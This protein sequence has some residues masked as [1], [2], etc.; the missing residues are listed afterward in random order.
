M[1]EHLYE[2][3][4]RK[5]AR[6]RETLTAEIEAAS[7]AFDSLSLLEPVTTWLDEFDSQLEELENALE[8]DD[9][10]DDAPFSEEEVEALKSWAEMFEEHVREGDDMQEECALGE[11]SE[12][13][14][15]VINRFV[16]I[17]LQ[18]VRT[19]SWELYHA[20]IGAA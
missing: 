2:S 4:R 11:D 5:V 16:N 7:E 3:D 8:D 9:C 10:D 1:S 19:T 18:P 17:F 13:V 12:E 6:A 20:A 14:T 15:S